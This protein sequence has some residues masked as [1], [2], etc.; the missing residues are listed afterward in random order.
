M[1]NKQEESLKFTSQKKIQEELET[2][3]QFYQKDIKSSPKHIPL[4]S[5]PSSEDTSKNNQILSNQVLTENKINTLD[6]DPSKIRSKI[7]SKYPNYDRIILQPSDLTLLKDFI[8]EQEVDGIKLE[9]YLPIL[10][11]IVILEGDTLNSEAIFTFHYLE[12]GNL[13][14]EFYSNFSA[15]FSLSCVVINEELANLRHN[16]PTEKIT[17]NPEILETLYKTAKANFDI[18]SRFF[19]FLDK[20][21]K[22]IQITNLNITK[23]NKLRIN[24]KNETK[25][26]KPVQVNLKIYRLNEEAHKLLKKDKRESEHKAGSF[27]RRGHWRKLKDG[28]RVWI[29]PSTIKNKNSENITPKE[30]RV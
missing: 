25:T 13:H 3:N 1:I 6:S 7:L 11:G 4:T 30:Y 22:E 12:D 23:H 28:R 24:N 29:N 27:T 17:N 14:L 16:L 18:L 5:V 9:S 21:E 15:D 10:N 8:A 2:L 26:K 20:H 19:I